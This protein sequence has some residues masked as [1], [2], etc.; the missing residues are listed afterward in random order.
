MPRFD[1]EIAR[2]LWWCL[3]LLDRRLAIET[4]RPFL[5]QDINV[6]VDLPHQVS[7]EWLGISHEAPN[8][9]DMSQT[10][11][12]M[13]SV[14]Y[15]VAMASYSRVIGKVWEALYG[16]ATSE[17]TPSPLLNEYLEHLI[18]QSQRGIRKEFTYDPHRPL[19]LMAGSL[20]WWQIKQRFIMRIVRPTSNSLQTGISHRLTNLILQRWTSLYLLVRKPM[21][22]KAWAPDQLAPDA[23]ENEV[24]CM[25]LA[26]SIFDDFNSMPEQHPKYT[27]P[28]LHYLTNATIIALGLIIKQSSFKRVY[29]E[30]TLRAAQSLWDHCRKTWVS[31]KMARTVWKLNQMADAIIN[32]GPFENGADRS[33]NPARVVGSER[34]HS[35]SSTPVGLT[36]SSAATP[37][38]SSHATSRLLDRDDL[39][40]TA[41]KLSGF[42]RPERADSS[43]AI[44]RYGKAQHDRPTGASTHISQP[45]HTNQLEE[46]TGLD[47]DIS[48]PGEMID[49]GMEWLQSLF[50]NGLDTQLPPVWD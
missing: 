1:G 45:D 28:F 37:L 18:T 15:L 32:N 48:L 21:L 26:Q 36:A 19:G 2:R 50:V 22:Q 17:S 6:D 11:P 40:N 23:I 10:E 38:T 14:P 43:H 27:F 42:N 35:P 24:I 34:S 12:V 13:T 25:R 44:G 9:S 49:G 8:Q 16:A 41:E 47:I 46:D 29:G 30:V 5:I 4:G 33:L 3:Y 7:D 39:A 31:G 20:A